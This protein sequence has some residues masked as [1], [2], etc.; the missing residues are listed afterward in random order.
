MKTKKL[1]YTA[2]LMAISV[3]GGSLLSFNIGIAKVAPV[4]HFINLISAVLLGPGYAILQA[5]GS[6]ILRNLL[7]TGTLL[8]F[9]GSMFGAGL[10]GYFYQRHQ[11]LM[12]LCQIGLM[13]Q[14]EVE[15]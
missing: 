15:R 3:V 6:S 13:S 14:N 2:M 8:A 11:N 9:P 1:V 7:G 10:A 5:F 12:A 4:Q